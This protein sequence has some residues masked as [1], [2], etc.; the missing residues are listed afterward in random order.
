MFTRKRAHSPDGSE[1]DNSFRQGQ[2]PHMGRPF[3]QHPHQRYSGGHQP[4]Q[5][6]QRHM[7]MSECP[8]EDGI[9]QLGESGSRN[10]DI[11]VFF[12]RLEHELSDKQNEN[13]IRQLVAKICRSVV[14]FPTRT[15]T[16]ATLIGLISGKHYDVAC[17]IIQTLHAS[18]PVYLEAQKWQEALSIIH[19]I[20]SLVNC[21]VIRPSA[22]LSNFDFLLETTLEDNVPQARSDYFVYTVLSS[23]PYVAWDL[24]QQEEIQENFEKILTT[25]ETYLSKRSKAHLD[26]TRVWKISSSTIQMDYLDSLWIQIKNFKANSWVENHLLKPYNDKDYR[27]MLTASLIPSDLP[28]F[29]IPGHS[30]Q[31]VYPS[32]RIVFRC[33][34]DDVVEKYKDIVKT[35]PGTDRIER[36]CIEQQIRMIIDENSTDVVNCARR[37]LHMT[38][39]EILPIRHMFVETILGELFALPKPKHDESLYHV[40]LIQFAKIFSNPDNPDEAKNDYE[41]VVHKAVGVLYD[42]IDDMSVICLNRFIRWFTFHVQNTKLV[43]PWQNWTDATQKDPTT[44]KAQFVH[45]VLGRLLRL[46][47]RKEIE[48]RLVQCEANFAGLMPEEPEIKCSPIFHN[49]PKAAELSATIRNLVA[50]KAEPQKICEDLNILI[51]GV[52]M[53]PEF[54]LK[55]EKLTDQLLKVDI[56]TAVILDMAKRSLTHLASALG[57]YLNVFKAL[58]RSSET[59][60][61]LL[62]TISSCLA[63]HSQ[64]LVIMVDKLFKAELVGSIEI[65][66]WLFSDTMRMQHYKSYPW[67]ILDYTT[68]RSRLIIEKLVAEKNKPKEDE[69]DKDANG[70]S[71]KKNDGSGT[72]NADEDID[73]SA[74]NDVTMKVENDNGDQSMQASQAELAKLDSKIISAREAHS[75]LILHIF[76][77]FSAALDDQRLQHDVCN[78]D[79]LIGRMQEIYYNHLDSTRDLENKIDTKNVLVNLNQ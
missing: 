33:F 4:F 2:Q 61:Q 28:T 66:N 64:L 37:L 55:E 44:K 20:S 77:L 59:Q 32:P 23:L 75:A 22:L 18:Y 53:P 69:K 27:D 35:I 25:I 7:H 13:R 1:S 78:R 47:F 41:H 57:K 31:Y 51:E 30:D 38:R 42:N 29:Q 10:S 49:H 50:Y 58:T 8:V 43:F 63:Q 15:G 67:E 74:D 46:N 6:R 79:W 36:F 26:V 62:Q 24:S 16:Y 72:P 12:Q 52:E 34:E 9:A 71:G 70:A 19:L 48:A 76:S 39:A 40:L 11:G 65:C 5:K 45:D 54:V 56:F 60:I 73:D 21:K 14:S 68:T 17:Q 3:Q